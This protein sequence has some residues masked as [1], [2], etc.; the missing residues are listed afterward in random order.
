VRC[1]IGSASFGPF[2]QFMAELCRFKLS[3]A[4]LLLLCWENDQDNDG[5]KAES[6]GSKCCL[7]S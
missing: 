3:D 2:R 7:G 6:T 4:N 1:R 5:T